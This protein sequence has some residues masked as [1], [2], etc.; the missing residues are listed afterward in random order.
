M[1]YLN[2]SYAM[3]RP[4][5]KRSHKPELD[6][7]R[8]VGVAVFTAQIFEALFVVVART[9]L[10]HPDAQQLEDIAPLSAKAYKQPVI[11]LLKE[12]T[13]QDQIDSVLAERIFALI[14][15]RNFLVHRIFLTK[16]MPSLSDSDFNEG[17]I[18]LCRRIYSESGAVAADLLDLFMSYST[19][20]PEAA[21][22]VLE[23]KAIIDDF[24]KQIYAIRSRVYT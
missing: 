5:H 22:F 10:K 1:A 15:D 8:V 23:H 14:E 18:H 21:E 13:S 4:L 24:R 9:A 19:R 20:F 6:P 16:G 2:V 3:N 12:L 17:L 7:M 11:A